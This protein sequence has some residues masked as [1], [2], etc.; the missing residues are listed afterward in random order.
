MTHPIFE[1][2][3]PPQGAHIYFVK[4]RECGGCLCASDNPLAHAPDQWPDACPQCGYE[5]IAVD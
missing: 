4:C 1:R 3:A 2:T 5:I